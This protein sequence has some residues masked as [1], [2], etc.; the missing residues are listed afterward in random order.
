MKEDYGQ[1]KKLFGQM[2]EERPSAQLLH[3]V[4]LRVEEERLRVAKV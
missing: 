4:L 3:T 1:Y 2:K